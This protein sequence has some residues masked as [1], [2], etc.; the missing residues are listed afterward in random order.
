MQSIYKR[1]VFYIGTVALLACQAQESAKNEPA[2][3]ASK[4]DP[5]AV[6]VV[7][8]MQAAIGMTEQWP[9]ARYISYYWVAAREGQK[10]A[11]HRHDWDRVTGRYRLEGVNREGQ[12]V[13]S[14]F[15][16]NT[17]HGDVFLDGQKVTV[18][19]MR[20]KFLEGAYASYINDSYWFLMPFKLKEPGVILT[21][22]A[23]RQADGNI[24]DVVKVTFDSVGLTPGDT[25]W[26]YVD[27]KDNLI[28][29]WEYFL[30]GWPEDRPRSAS[31]WEDWQTFNGVKLA[32]NRAFE[33]RPVRIYFTHVNISSDVDEK[34][35]T[36]SQ[37]TL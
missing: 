2:F 20:Q 35:L 28:K 27:R 15:N 17:M 30:Q 1:I 36:S 14:L 8:G 7:D 26:V 5:K 4:S 18:D 12:H 22:D 32:L 24:F 11:E 10:L 23:E 31:L 3:D 6:Q 25:Y 16:V 29:K 21:Y 37:E 33:G 34:A 13:V 9:Q 19:S